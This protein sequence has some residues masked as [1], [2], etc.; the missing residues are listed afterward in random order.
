M[1]ERGEIILVFSAALVLLVALSAW[2]PCEAF[3]TG[4]SGVKLIQVENL[5]A[6]HYSTVT[7][8]YNGHDID[9]GS[10]ISPFQLRPSVYVKGGESYSV[11]P[12]LFSLLS[13][14]LYIAFGFAGLYV[15]PVCSG[16]LCIPLIYAIS[17][18]FVPHR[19][20]LLAAAL[21]MFGT[22]M[23]FYSLT[24]WEH[25]P[26][27]CLFLAFVWLLM[28]RMNSRLATVIA[29]SLLGLSVWLR[30]EMLVLVLISCA[31]GLV[32]LRRPRSVWLCVAGMTASL[33]GLLAVNM[34]LYG[35]WLGHVTRNIHLS[36]IPGTV[37]A[38]SARLSNLW[39]SLFGINAPQALSAVSA[40]G[41]QA[42]A[43]T[44]SSIGLEF[45][46]FFA[47]AGILGSS[48]VT[49]ARRYRCAQQVPASDDRLASAGTV[50]LTTAV[51]I[52]MLL[53][54]AA[55]V[56]LYLVTMTQDRS[57]L[58]SVLK[59]GGVFTFS[60][61]LAMA[62]VW[63]W[64]SS[65]GRSNVREFLW[66][67]CTSAAFVIIM[68]VLAP[69]NG[70]IRYGA[71]YLL[72]VIPLLVILAVTAFHAVCQG[73]WRR[74]FQI[75]M[76]LL[77]MFSLLIEARG[78]QILYHKKVFSRDLTASLMASPSTRIAALFWWIPFEVPRVIL[79]KKVH[80]VF[81]WDGL[82]R[83]VKGAGQV[84]DKTV[85]IVLPGKIANLP[86]VEGA[87]QVDRKEV[88]CP[89]DS[90]FCVTIFRLAI[91]REE[92]QLPASQPASAT[93]QPTVPANG[94]QDSR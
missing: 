61:F 48:I 19:F 81:N 49:I 54:L 34:A 31:A 4:D 88:A 16:L 27:V 76:A 72:P 18:H 70:G 90:Y 25:T 93:R 14:L 45:L 80:M 78:Y 42:G 51:W 5:V 62:L 10:T 87:V 89:F 69:N 39:T 74:V 29:G 21:V 92:G 22:P 11:F 2:L 47:V 82:G 15:L 66:L 79:K 17:R 60:P 3:Y 77:V 35:E 55:A 24:F 43:M 46:A 67:L 94:A 37:A 8:R 6:N 40:E 86:F 36:G 65:A 75:I 20:S 23:F 50:R 13:S 91:Q 59:S 68:P 58:I 12:V 53:V 84:G 41:A 56:G 28:S 26:A 32:F 7:L 38:A 1:K 52:G 85:D 33:A 64:Q 57:P 44:K 63:P 73:P 83:C 9:P 30:T 71:R